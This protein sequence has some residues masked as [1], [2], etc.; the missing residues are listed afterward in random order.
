MHPS[1]PYAKQVLVLLATMIVITSSCSRHDA[2][3]KVWFYT[4]DDTK[5]A[6]NDDSDPASG[7]PELNPTHF[8]N[9]QANGQYTAWLEEFTYG[10]WDLDKGI[11]RSYRAQ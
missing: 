9:L 7:D 4:Y 2:L 10:S 8:I 11:D 5:S 3:S 6:N 1:N